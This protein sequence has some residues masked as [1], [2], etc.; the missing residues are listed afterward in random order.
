MWTE[1]MHSPASARRWATTS[2]S[3]ICSRAMRNMTGFRLEFSMV[4]PLPCVALA[5]WLQ[6]ASATWGT[7]RDDYAVR[8][9]V[10]RAGPREDYLR[11]LETFTHC[12]CRGGGAGGDAELAEDVRDVVADRAVTH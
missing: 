5:S 6:N 2:V 9:T 12:Q 4:A 8:R 10:F 1:S 7:H 3:S 11:R